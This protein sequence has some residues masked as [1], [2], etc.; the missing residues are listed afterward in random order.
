M[1]WFNW[2]SAEDDYRKSLAV[3]QIEHNANH[4]DMTPEQDERYHLHNRLANNGLDAKRITFGR[5][6]VK[7]GEV[8]DDR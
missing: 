6:L 5:H 2:A 8:S 3:W 1:I 4:K 7:S